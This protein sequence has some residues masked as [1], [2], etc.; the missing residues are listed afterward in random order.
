MELQ[1]PSCQKRLS[2]G[3]QFA[4]QLV[5]CPA[6]NGVFMA[7]SLTPPAPAT[8]TP[9]AN[10]PSTS[11][12]DGNILPFDSDAPPPRP[13]IAHFTSS[14]PPPPPRPR[15]EDEPIGPPGDY[16]TEHRCHLRA[17]ILRWFTPGILLILLLVS[18]MNWIVIPPIARNLWQLAFDPIDAGYVIY[19]LVTFFVALPL[20]WV[21]ILMEINVIPLPPAIRPFWSWR[22]L[23]M[24]FLLFLTVLFP[25]IDLLRWNLSAAVDP[26]GLGL[27]IAVRLHWLAIACGGLE[28]WLDRRRKKRLPPPEFS[29]RL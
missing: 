28:F 2:I 24:T 13:E 16:T 11:T 27:K 17:N 18:F 8:P 6:C 19:T 10:A 21:V 25:T 22:G 1:C 7:P 14:P 23:V 20:A 5:K 3:D 9:A 4:G 15:Y 26:S 12:G 29:L